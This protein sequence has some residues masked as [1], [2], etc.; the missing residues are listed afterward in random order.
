MAI[1]LYPIEPICVQPPRPSILRP[2]ERNESADVSKR[3]GRGGKGGGE[4]ARG[5]RQAPVE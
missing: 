5:M 2:S 3:G 1:V 4:A